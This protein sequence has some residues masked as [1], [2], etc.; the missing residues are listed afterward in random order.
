MFGVVDD[1]FPWFFFDVFSILHDTTLPETEELVACSYE[2]L[3][4]NPTAMLM[5]FLHVL[6]ISF[7]RSSV[8]LYFLM[9]YTAFNCA[10]RTSF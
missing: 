6:S 2:L 9:Q 8:T 5:I 1:V 10:F 3:I 4:R 7:L